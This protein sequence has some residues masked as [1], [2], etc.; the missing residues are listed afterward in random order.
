[1]DIEQRANE[2]A[3]NKAKSERWSLNVAILA[4]AIL[5]AIVLLRFEGV[6]IEVVAPI[7]IFGLAAV[8]LIGLEREKRLQKNLYYQELQQLQEAP[9]VE[10]AEALVPSPLNPERNRG[11]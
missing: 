2:R 9:W 4:D 3:K 7:A 1:M 6:A 5:A 11:T 8:W 10:K